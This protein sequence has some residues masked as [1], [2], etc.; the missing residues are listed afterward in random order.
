MIYL[1][2][3]HLERIEADMSM[4]TITLHKWFW[5]NHV[6]PYL[7]SE[8]FLKFSEGGETEDHQTI[9]NYTQSC[10]K[11][12]VADIPTTSGLKRKKKATLKRI[13]KRKKQEQPPEI[14]LCGECK[15]TLKINPANFNEES[16]GCDRCP[17]WYHFV[18][19]G[20]KEGNEATHEQKW[21]CIKCRTEM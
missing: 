2:R 7:L 11:P 15:K 1:Y 9:D 3:F 4:W 21:H 19:V 17:I 12:T 5:L 13:I 20:I 14:Y 18:C 10:S 8:E 6:C 16:V